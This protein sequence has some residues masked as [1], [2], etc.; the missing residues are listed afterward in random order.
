MQFYFA[1]NEIK[2]FLSDYSCPIFTYNWSKKCKF[3]YSSFLVIDFFYKKVKNPLQS[4]FLFFFIFVFFSNLLLRMN[5]FVKKIN[6]KH[7]DENRFVRTL[8]ALIRP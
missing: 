4:Q 5:T 2:F 7:L 8:F 1:E 6:N 3:I